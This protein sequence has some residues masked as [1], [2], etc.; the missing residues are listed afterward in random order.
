MSSRPLE[1][2]SGG[3]EPLKIWNCVNC[4]RRKVRCDRRDPCLQC[5]RNKIECVFPISGRIPSRSRVGDR[6]GQKQF[7]LVRRLRR[8][9]A[10]VG[11]LSS[12]V[13]N[14]AGINQSHPPAESPIISASATS[15]Q[16]FGISNG[17]SGASQV[18]EDFGVLEVARNGDLV[19]GEGFWTVFCKEVCTVSTPRPSTNLC[20][21]CVASLVTGV[22]CEL[23]TDL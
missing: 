16:S 4:R 8:L 18:P 13:E 23:L 9:E 17:T 22:F 21:L 3:A 2:A 10:M 14:A 1:S 6:A 15:E 11:G 5:T 20:Q 12:Q 7:E 19:V